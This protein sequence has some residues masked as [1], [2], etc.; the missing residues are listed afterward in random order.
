M[1]KH[2]RLIVF[3]AFFTTLFL[4]VF[5][6]FKPLPPDLGS[7]QSLEAVGEVIE[8]YNDLQRK[9]TNQL[10]WQE[11]QIGDGVI[12]DDLIR[13]GN[14]STGRIKLMDGLGI[15]LE[16]NTIVKIGK[17]ETKVDLDIFSGDMQLSNETTLK[18]NLKAGS[19]KFQMGKGSIGI[20]KD[21]TDNIELDVYSGELST[22]DGK[23]SSNQRLEV[24][25]GKAVTSNILL[26]VLAPHNLQD[27]Y[28]DANSEALFEWAVKDKEL[29]VSI[30]LGEKKMN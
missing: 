12:S 7:G 2:L 5:I 11:I 29:K 6:Y 8:A 21:Q 22:S 26:K 3:S 9:S 27:S 19:K 10:I 25:N 16:P 24:N 20:R 15:S 14:K 1:S 30:Y 23:L 17:N 18:V 4:S 28:L 13:T